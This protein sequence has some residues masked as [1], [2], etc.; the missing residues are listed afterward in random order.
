MP[1][2]PGPRPRLP[3]DDEADDYR[4]RCSARLLQARQRSGLSTYELARRARIPDA[5]IITRY[6]TEGV[7]PT[8]RRMLALAHALDVTPDEVWSFGLREGDETDDGS[9]G[10]FVPFEHRGPGGADIV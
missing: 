1:A 7:L 5:S 9:R 2:H 10:G 4:L 6:E 3:F 8:P